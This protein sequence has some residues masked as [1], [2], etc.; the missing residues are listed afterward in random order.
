MKRLGA[1]WGFVFAFLLLSQAQEKSTYVTNTGAKADF[2]KIT[3][4]DYTPEIRA[5]MKRLY[6]D[7]I[8]L[9]VHFGPYAV[10][11]GEWN[12]KPGAAEW[13][14]RRSEISIPVYE[15]E[16]AAKFNPTRFKAEEWVEVA[17]KGGMGFMVVTS[18]HHDGFAMFKSKHP[19]N[20]YDFVGLN[21]DLMGELASACKKSDI[22][23]GFYYSQSQDWH[24][25][26]GVGNDWDFPGKNIHNPALFGHYFDE[27]VVPQVTE[28]A[29]GYDDLFMVWFDTPAALKDEQCEQLLSIIRKNQPGALV[30][31]RL[32]NGYGHF[33]VSLDFGTTPSVN[34]ATWLPDLKVPWQTHGTVAASW[35]YV[36]RHS[37]L[38]R[39]RDHE[40]FIYTFCN[41][42]SHGGVYLLNVAPRGDGSIPEHQVNSIAAVGD[43]L[44]INGEAIYDA[45][46]SPFTFPPYAIT[47]KPG[48][49]YILLQTSEAAE[50]IQLNGLLTKVE[51]VQCMTATGKQKIKFKQQ[52]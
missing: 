45:D 8:G 15:Q 35:G 46:P 42:V 36:K 51:E 1:V 27:K 49:M 40:K 43:W 4:D 34:T 14:M 31:S 41:I 44:H 11:G 39:A 21:R 12:G 2:G 10:L 50:P 25:E 23:L 24:E 26:G 19:Y 7:K 28:L 18:K 13:I 29:T 5:N 32:G 6:H 22:G 47:T 30:N 52:G 9:F 17:K 16:A 33:D 20:I 38:D 3:A 48:K 37:E